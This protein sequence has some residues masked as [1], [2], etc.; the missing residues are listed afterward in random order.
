M[1]RDLTEYFPCMKQ[2]SHHLVNL[3]IYIERCKIAK[4]IVFS[5]VSHV[6]AVRGMTKNLNRAMHDCILRPPAVLTDPV[7][8]R[9]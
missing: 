8:Y 9:D 5:V 2:R 6:R 4:R 1:E 7:V 3:Q